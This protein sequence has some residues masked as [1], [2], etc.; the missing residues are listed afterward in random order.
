MPLP[1]EYYFNKLYPLQDRVLKA[2]AACETDFYLTG[3]TAL[4]RWYLHHRF[5]DDLHCFVNDVPYRSGGTES[6]DLFP[7]VDNWWNILSNKI[8]ALARRE[9]KDVADIVF[10]CR[11]YHFTWQNVSREFFSRVQWIDDVSLQ[12][13]PLQRLPFHPESPVRNVS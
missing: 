1:R 7:R 4:S 6:F 3:G 12:L 11:R 13:T 9:P 2:I 10:L 8:T 5:S